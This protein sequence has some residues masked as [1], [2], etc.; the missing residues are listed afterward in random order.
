MELVNAT[1][2]VAGHTMALD[3]HGREHLVVVVKGTFRFPLPDEPP[4]HFALHDEQQPLVMADSF[5]G[6]PGL[7][8]PVYDVDFALR[9]PRC[10]ILLVGSAHA[11]GGKPVARVEVG[12]RVGTWSKTLAVTGARRWECGASGASP[13]A[14]ER[15]VK[16]PISYDVAFGGTDARHEDPRQHAA[17]LANP[18]GCGFH[19]HLRSDWVDGAAMPR[20]EETD[21]PVRSPDGDYRPMAFGPIGRAWPPRVGFAGTYDEAWLEE[22]FPFLPPDFDEQYFQAAPPDQQ[23]PLGYFDRG[24]VEV[25]LANLTPE[26]L[27]RF[28]VPQLVAPVNVFPRHGERE[29]HVATLDTLLIE[30]DQRR[31]SLTWRVTRPLKKNMF[32][33]VQVLVGRKGRDWWQQREAPV[34]PIPVVMVPWLPQEEG[35][36]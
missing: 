5:T 3:K 28:T 31:F 25:A 6:E 18:V 4:G 17:F 34:F 32:E 24:P 21:R 16:Q 22:H 2:M 20:T 11:P 1:R 19:R 10:D 12:V 33:V 36:A 8:A 15:F 7:S 29:D 9:K 14:P 13:G 23:V 35:A 27:T 26:G 30:P